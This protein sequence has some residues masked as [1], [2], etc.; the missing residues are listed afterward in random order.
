MK[1]TLL[2]LSLILLTGSGCR[3]HD[4]CAYGTPQIITNESVTNPGTNT[5]AVPEP[6]TVWLLLLGL[7]VVGLLDVY[8]RLER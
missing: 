4:D 1:I 8:A 2:F 5:S 7:G 6:S 3:H